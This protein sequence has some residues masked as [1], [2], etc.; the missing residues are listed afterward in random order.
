MSLFQIMNDF[1]VRDIYL[2]QYYS[3][4]QINLLNLLF[5][6]Q[7]CSGFCAHAFLYSRKH[8]VYRTI[9]LIEFFLQPYLLHLSYGV[10]I[11]ILSTLPLVGAV[12]HNPRKK[13]LRKCLSTDR[14]ARIFILPA[15]SHEKFKRFFLFSVLCFFLSA[16]G[17]Q[18]SA[19]KKWKRR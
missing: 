15:T 11:V 1:V 8:I 2:L 7:F 18:I 17:N 5:F 16:E 10:L 9:H 13:T 4:S 14:I 6:N 19:V 12:S 3:F